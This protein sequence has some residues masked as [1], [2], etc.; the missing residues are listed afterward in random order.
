MEYRI[1]RSRPEGILC[2]YRAQVKS[3]F[4]FWRIWE[5]ISDWQW[6]E[7]DAEIYIKTHSKGSCDMSAVKTVFEF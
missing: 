7:R 2:S 3:R 6:T 5:N 1:L 4:L